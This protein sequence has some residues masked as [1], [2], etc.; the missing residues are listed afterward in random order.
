MW[1][2]AE[3]CQ[4]S[5]VSESL[6]VVPEGLTYKPRRLKPKLS[7]RPQ[8][9]ENAKTVRSV[10]SKWWALCT[11]RDRSCVGCDGQGHRAGV[12]KPFGTHVPPVCMH[13]GCGTWCYRISCFPCGLPILL[14]STPFLFSPNAS[15]LVWGC[16]SHAFVT[17]FWHLFFILQAFA[18]SLRGDSGLTLLNSVT[19]AHSSWEDFPGGPNAFHIVRWRGDSEGLEHD[20]MV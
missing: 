15:R 5:P 13:P 2:L 14:R 9:V 7:R 11:S 6:L 3:D 19:A 20:V 16:L 4:G 1:Y 10:Q 18:F 17:C 12:P 8:D